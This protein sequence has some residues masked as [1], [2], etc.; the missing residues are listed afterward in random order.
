MERIVKFYPAY[1]KRDKNPSKNY[2]ISGVKMGMYLKGKL[3][4]IQFVVSTHWHLPHVQNELVKKNVGD[5]LGLKCSF[6]PSPT[7]LGYHSPK[8]LYEG[9]E[10]ITENCE[11]TGGICY[12]DGSGL[13]AD[14]VFKILVEKGDED[15]WKFLEQEYIDRFGELK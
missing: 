10:P 2:G 6:I 14:D 13:R 7:D 9:Q 5:A 4:T 1:D 15:V 11:W 12:Y 8:P 3:G